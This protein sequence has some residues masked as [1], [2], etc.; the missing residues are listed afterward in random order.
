[1]SARGRWRRPRRATAPL[2]PSPL[3]DPV[4]FQGGWDASAERRESIRAGV[5]ASPGR[6]LDAVSARPQESAS[7]LLARVT[8]APA[9]GVVRVRM[10]S[11]PEQPE[12]RRW[13][14]P[15]AFDPEREPTPTRGP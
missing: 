15:P 4:P 5:P 9:A 11:S 13:D 7:L 2:A 10:V 14:G 12:A 8:S 3:P 1:M 6:E